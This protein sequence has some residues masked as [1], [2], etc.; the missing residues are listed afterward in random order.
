MLVSYHGVIREGQ[1]QLQGPATLPEGAQVLL[2]I[3]PP[4]QV[5]SQEQRLTTL[6]TEV[7]Q[8]P[9]DEFMTNPETE[10]T[11]IDLDLVSDQ[12]LVDLVHQV[13]EERA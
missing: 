9:F 10:N 4:E 12:T 1:I 7:W 13:R 6:S 5:E 2:V 11:V 3:S 8:A